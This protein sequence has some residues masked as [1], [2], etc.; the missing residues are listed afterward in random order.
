MPELSPDKFADWPG[1]NR[2]A[3]SAGKFRMLLP[4][5]IAEIEGDRLIAPGFAHET[6]AIERLD[7]ETLRLDC[8][9][10]FPGVPAAECGL[11]G[12]THLATCV[13]T[14]GPALEARVSELYAARQA[15]SAWVMGEVGI[16]V[17][18]AFTQGATARVTHAAAAKGLK[19]GRPLQPGNQ[20]LEF[21]HQ[22]TVAELAGA[23][24]I[25]VTVMPRGMMRPVNS[26]SMLIG[27]GKGLT[28]QRAHDCATCKARE[29]CRYRN[30][31]HLDAAA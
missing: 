14:I 23:A 13:G 30:V 21:A 19:A 3:G 17:L 24:S 27:L 15:A 16:A 11:I 25:G 20:G 26:L 6:H 8:G 29:R 22:E 31:K 12:A 7:G 4:E 5:V 28:A 18:F 10:E 1:F 9:T 2:G